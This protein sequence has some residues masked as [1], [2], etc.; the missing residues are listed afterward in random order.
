MFTT[1][2][3]ERRGRCATCKMIHDSV[4]AASGPSFVADFRYLFFSQR[5][6]EDGGPLRVDVHPALAQTSS[7][8]E[9]LRL[10]IY[11]T[12]GESCHLHV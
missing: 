10:Q 3:E 1:D 6:T 12:P 2:L 5:V 8:A 11:T 4:A 9:K 7:S